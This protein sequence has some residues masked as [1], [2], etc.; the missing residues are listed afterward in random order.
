ME[1]SF[2][3]YLERP[4]QVA[5][6]ECLQGDRKLLPAGIQVVLHHLYMRTHTHTQN[7][8]YQTH[9]KTQDTNTA[10]CKAF[11]GNIIIII[12]L[13]FSAPL[14]CAPAAIFHHLL[15]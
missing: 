6:A 10:I 14:F 8:E 12:K 9:R 15:F 3:G 13:S 11:G 2:G 7:T 4:F 5:A 1:F